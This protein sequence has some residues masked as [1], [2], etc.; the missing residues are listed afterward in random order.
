[1]KYLKLF[2]HNIK[3]SDPLSINHPLRNFSRKLEDVIM[4]LQELDNLKNST[5][6]RYFHDDERISIVY[7]Y[8]YNKLLNISMNI[9]N[10]ESVLL[11]VTTYKMR[12]EKNK[13]K[14]TN[15]FI[16]FIKLALKDYYIEQATINYNKIIYFRFQ[17]NEVDV[18]LK[19]VEDYYIYNDAN[20]YNL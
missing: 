5:V 15:I 7:K 2:E 13:D 6:R 17:L 10:D 12:Y 19:E 1:M 11:T 8:D 14:N 16:D 9:E 20:K 18:V 4:S 3:H